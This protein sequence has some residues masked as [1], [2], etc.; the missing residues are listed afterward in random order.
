MNPDYSDARQPDRRTDSVSSRDGNFKVAST[1]RPGGRWQPPEPEVLQAQLPQYKVFEILGCG[2]MGAV[3]KG[4]QVSLDRYVAIK[5]LPPAVSE[6]DAQFSARFKQEAKTMARFQHPGIV[7]IYDAGE[8]SAGLLYIVMEFI[9]GTDVALMTRAQGKLPQEYAL[10]ITAHVCD[11]LQYAHSHGVIHRDIK[12][13]NVLINMEGAVKV[14]DFGLAKATDYGQMALT[15]E[16]VAMGTPDYLAPEGMVMGITLDGRADIYSVGVMLYHM[17]TGKLPRGM[18]ELPSL[19]TRG[20]TDVR[21]DT[22]IA[23]AMD[24]ER[25]NRY[26]TAAEMRQDLDVIISTPRLLAEGASSSVFQKKDLALVHQHVAARKPVARRPGPGNVHPPG[27]RPVTYVPE[28]KR[29]MVPAFLIGA[30]VVACG[31]LAWMKFGNPHPATPAPVASGATSTAGTLSSSALL[32]EGVHTFGGHRYKFLPGPFSKDEERTKATALGG[33][34]L[35]INSASEDRWIENTFGKLITLNVRGQCRIGGSG[36]QDGKWSWQSGEPWSYTNWAIGSP[37][38]PTSNANLVLKYDN[39]VFRWGN[40]FWSDKGSTIIEWD[41]TTTPIPVEALSASLASAMPAPADALSFGGHRYKLIRG[42]RH[43]N[44]ANADAAAMGGHLATLT[45]PEED[46]WVRKTFVD[47]LPPERIVHIGAYKPNDSDQWLWITGEPWSHENWRRLQETMEPRGAYYQNFGGGT[48]RWVANWHPTYRINIASGPEEGEQRTVGFLVEWDSDRVASSTAPA[49]L[50][51]E[52][53]TEHGGHRYQMVKESLKWD[54]AKAK[55]ESM[56]GHLA[57]ITS[58]EERDAV[59]KM[60]LAAGMERKHVLLGGL[61]EFDGAPFVWVTGEPFDLALWGKPGPDGSGR[62][63]TSLYHAGSPR[64]WDDVTSDQTHAFLVEW[65]A[66]VPAVAPTL[67]TVGPIVD[68]LATVNLKRDVVRNT[69]ETKPEGLFT[70]PKSDPIQV[71][72]FSAAPPEEYDYEVEFTIA[73]GTRELV[74]IFPVPSGSIVFHMGPYSDDPAAFGF[75]GNLDGMGLKDPRTEAMARVPRFKNGQ[76]YRCLVEVRKGSLRA[77]LDGREIVKWSG[78]SARMKT[79]SWAEL[80]NK[81]H[82]GIAA[83]N[84]AVTF[85]R[86]ELRFRGYVPD[87]IAQLGTQFKEAWEREVTNGTAKAIADLDGKYLAAIDRTLADAT[88]AGRLDDV[89]ALRDEKQRLSSKAPLP[90]SDPA[91]IVPSLKKL[92]DTYRNSVAPLVKQHDAATKQAYARYDAALDAFQTELT[93]KNQLNDALMVKA[94]RTELDKARAPVAAPAVVVASASLT[95]LPASTSGTPTPPSASKP[96]PKQLTGSAATSLPEDMLKEPPPKP[97]TPDEAVQWALSLG[98]SARIK[99]GINESEITDITQFP[100]G[101]FTL[102]GLKL[103]E[104]QPLRVASLAALS[105]LTELQDLALDNNLITDAGL[106]FL[107]VLPKLQ[108]LSVNNCGLTDGALGHVAKQTTLVELS[109]RNN[110]I[111]GAGLKHLAVLPGLSILR[112]GSTDLSNDGI[113]FMASLVALQKLDLDCEKPLKVESLAPLAGIKKLKSLTLGS[114]ATDPLVSSLR[115][116]TTL[117]TL[118]LTRAPISDDAMDGVA[119]LKGLKELILYRCPNLTDYGMTKLVTLRGLL[120]FDVGYTRLTDSGFK[121]LSMKI[122]D[123][124]ELNVASSGMSDSGLAGLEN[125]R[126][127]TRLT[128]HV[129][130]CTDLGTGY[131]RRVSGLKLISI[132]QMETLNPA[133]MA[134]LKKDLPYVDFGR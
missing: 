121:T 56:G 8:T 27:A 129:R 76:R 14:A 45:T 114:S 97:F 50:T 43:W 83:Y 117:E 111:T 16:D 106:A 128:V 86:A 22:I 10:A 95:P 77:V 67:A 26:Q 37:S 70:T 3:Y 103:G 49:T 59:A 123:V 61:Q 38:G 13:A 119:A 133:R 81:K 55:A 25:E 46:E 115:A 1:T 80:P 94:T 118:D 60:V 53:V 78:N 34:L 40:T 88:K 7:S 105:R 107:P 58:V 90:D 72:E 122:S 116:L 131:I 73:S 62:R 31:F 6:E 29:P 127:I 79:T 89:V 75:G 30:L 124:E 66:A 108:H 74:Q 98:G 113:P 99:K 85:H 4:W 32:P 68:L 64:Y 91:N 5:I 57:T 112:I 2:G 87:R 54:D 48:S 28:K 69:W 96:A 92:R 47:T 93:Q 52:K 33:H 82:V 44:E 84:T 15:R 41:D 19:L 12:P 132:D 36:T 35:T 109:A 100:K 39:N 23:R 134:A 63:L 18:F 130:T 9:E 102:T 101:K 11:A 21:F 65:E 110:R 42:F 104:K 51:A 20:E 120:K 17:L 126:K 125:M 24:T 71:L